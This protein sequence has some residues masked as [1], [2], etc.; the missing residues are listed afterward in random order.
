MLAAVPP[1][2]PQLIYAL[3]LALKHVVSAA[4]SDEL[5]E[6]AL[7]PDY[8]DALADVCLAVAKPA[9]ADFLLSYLERRQ[10]RGPRVGDFVRQAAASMSADKFDSLCENARRLNA[11]VGLAQQLAVCEGLG[12]AAKRLKKTL[13]ADLQE[14]S[15]AVT[16]RALE[17]TDPK[18]LE[19]G[20]EAS[21]A[22][23]TPAVMSAWEKIVL[24]SRGVNLRTAALRLFP[25]DTR[26]R[27]VAIRA[28]EQGADGRLLDPVI[29]RLSPE[30]AGEAARRALADALI[31][32]TP[33]QSVPL[34]TALAGTEDG[35]PRLLSLA[36]DGVVP[37]RLLLRTSVTSALESRSAGIR[38]RV[39]RLTSE[40]PSETVRL[41]QVIAARVANYQPKR[42]DLANGAKIFALHCAACHRYKEIGANIGPSLDGIGVRG[43]A[44]L[45]ED[46]LDPSRNI[47]PAFQRTTVRLKS[48]EEFVGMNLQASAEAVTLTEIG[49]K[50]LRLT[51]SEVG[52]TK[53]ETVSVMP[54]AFEQL[55][56]P[57]ELGDLVAYL[58]K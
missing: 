4:S 48:G 7:K 1:K 46:I 26:G 8:A 51:A 30:A 50:H 43:A 57:E 54:Q 42:A 56:A 25:T 17:N 5:R 52:A 31:R 49:G 21:A 40:L 19:R 24:S 53:T 6:W 37:P 44:R 16:L 35:A 13:P 29:A 15:E 45:F 11:T 12:L 23:A 33:E 28:L 3:R 18:L 34:A 38:S 47:D 10:F 55:I 41:D 36:E 9:A 22:L 20:L 58:M 32:A 27:D 2:D 14:W 39:A